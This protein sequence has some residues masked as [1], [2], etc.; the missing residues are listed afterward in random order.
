MAGFWTNPHP[1]A[2]IDLGVTPTLTPKANVARNVAKNE[3]ASQK[4]QFY[5]G[6]MMEKH[7]SLKVK[8]GDRRGS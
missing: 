3:P 4:V 1:H 7:I 8:R 2:W 5:W 6:F